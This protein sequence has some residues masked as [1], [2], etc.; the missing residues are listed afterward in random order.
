MFESVFKTSVANE[1]IFKDEEALLLNYVKHEMPGLTYAG[2]RT[3]YAV[4]RYTFHGVSPKHVLGYKNKKTQDELSLALHLPNGLD[5]SLERTDDGGLAIIVPRRDK[6]ILSLGDGIR[7]MQTIPK[8]AGEMLAYIGECADGKPALL[9]FNNC[10]HWLIGGTTG[11]GKTVCMRNILFSMMERYSPDELHIYLADHKNNMTNFDNIAYVKRQ[12][13]NAAEILAM[14][15]ELVAIMKER[16]TLMGEMNISEYN[17]EHPNAKLPR[18]LV[19]FDEADNVIGQGTG[20]N[21]DG[22]RR[23]VQYLAAE[24]RSCGIHLILASQK[25]I[26]ANINTRISSNLPGRIALRVANQHD[27]RSI[28]GVKGAERL[29]GRGDAYFQEEVGNNRRMQCAYASLE[30][31]REA[32]EVLRKVYGA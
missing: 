14:F 8:E 2:G 7:E 30:E 26:G 28:I 20:A 22:V 5:C 23:Q 11:S 13:R 4:R 31:T 21:S 6:N 10:P 15:Q 18:I 24:A 17:N 16:I 9:D 32:K 25:A 29:T 12:A 19:V 1:G 27:S 3:S